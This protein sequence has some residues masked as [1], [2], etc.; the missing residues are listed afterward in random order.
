MTRRHALVALVLAALAGS[1]CAPILRRDSSIRVL[2]YNIHAGKDAAGADN[3]ADVAALI[4]TTGADVVLLQEVDRRTKRSGVTDQLQSLID[5]TGYQGVFGKSL[6][7][8]GG[9]YGVAALSRHGF[10][11]DF[12]SPLQVTP[13]QTRAGGSHEPRVVQTA[14]AMTRRGRLQ[15]FN[16]HLDAS[17]TAEYRIQEVTQLLL[18]VRVR[19]SAATPVVVGGDFNAEP[20]SAPIKAMLDAGLR[21]AWTECGQGDGFTYPTAAPVK[22]IDYLFLSQGLRCSSAQVLDSTA[23]DHRPLLVTLED[24]GWDGK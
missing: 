8:D 1:S 11:F 22:R 21:D 6:D 9:E 10:T 2:V 7:Y 23:S 5:A 24:V 13:V 17:A 20:G 4:R 3:L 18:P 14:A 15:A 16:T 12:T 19:M